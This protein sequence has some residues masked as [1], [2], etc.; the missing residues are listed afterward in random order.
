MCCKSYDTRPTKKGP[1]NSA[2]LIYV[3]TAGIPMPNKT[4]SNIVISRAKLKMIT[5]TT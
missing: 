4:A 1:I 2:T 3:G 5:L